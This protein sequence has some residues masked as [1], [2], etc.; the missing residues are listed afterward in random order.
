MGV[1]Y[2]KAIKEAGPMHVEPHTL[3]NWAKV[4]IF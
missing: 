3:L 2:V 1:T 4:Q